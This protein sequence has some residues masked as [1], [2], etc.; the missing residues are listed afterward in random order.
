MSYTSRAQ[1]GMSFTGVLF[2]LIFV[3]LVATMGLRIIPM[4]IEY[5][6]VLRSITQLQN[7]PGYPF[8]KNDFYRKLENQLYLNDAKDFRPL[9]RDSVKIVHDKKSGEKKLI[10]SYE[11]KA[12]FFRNIY[13]MAKFEKEGP[14]KGKFD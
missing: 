4:F 5:Q 3:G 8:S 9:V 6:A 7:T 2:I 14:V 11:R 12:P 13:F 10:V 1:R